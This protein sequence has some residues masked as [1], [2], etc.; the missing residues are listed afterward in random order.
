LPP[1]VPPPPPPSPPVYGNPYGGQYGRSG[2]YDGGPSPRL[3]SEGALRPAS[4]VLDTGPSSA[5]SRTGR[6]RRHVRGGG[7]SMPDTEI[8]VSGAPTV[9]ATRV[10]SSA[11]VE[12]SPMMIDSPEKL[13]ELLSS[14]AEIE[15]TPEA[16]ESLR[17]MLDQL[18]GVLDRLATDFGINRNEAEAKF[19]ALGRTTTQNGQR[20]VIIERFAI[21]KLTHDDVDLSGASISYT[22]SGV[23][24]AQQLAD[25]AGLQ[26]V[27][28]GHTH[29]DNYRIT[30]DEYT[31]EEGRSKFS[32]GDIHNINRNYRLP[33]IDDL[34]ELKGLATTNFMVINPDPRSGRVT[35][36]LTDNRV[37]GIYTRQGSFDTSTSTITLENG[38]QLMDGSVP[39]VI[40]IPESADET[41]GK[42][43]PESERESLEDLELFIVDEK[44]TP[45][46][47]AERSE[48]R[49]RAH[50]FI[51][52][53]P[54]LED[55]ARAGGLSKELAARVYK[56]LLLYLSDNSVT[57]LEREDPSI[58][59]NLKL[60]TEE[61]VDLYYGGRDDIESARIVNI[62]AKFARDNGIF[63]FNRGDLMTNI[64]A[65]SAMYDQVKDITLIKSP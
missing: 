40:E 15:L 20:K 44:K 9:E 56:Q 7:G 21:P 23:R 41:T 42:S 4:V 62:L 29:P 55:A 30:G 53:S 50:L 6:R 45:V 61:A 1:V 54:E 12:I 16:H 58:D 25:A 38:W 13:A 48:A 19:V 51:S 63:E 60:M 39:L 11:P 65:L 26:I 28:D 37:D 35:M 31:L 33:S 10:D 18:P 64:F 5:T 17:Q 32:P 27:Y 59:S 43:T 47:P 36:T 46:A 52:S 14:P 3:R 24:K 49:E 22:E 8:A 57:E 2:R 34:N